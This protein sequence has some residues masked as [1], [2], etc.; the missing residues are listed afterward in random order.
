MRL[1]CIHERACLYLR[2]QFDRRER[3]NGLLRAS[4]ASDLRLSA[5][6]SLQSGVS[7]PPLGITTALVK[8]LVSPGSR[9]VRADLLVPWH[10]AKRWSSQN[11]PGRGAGTVT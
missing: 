10:A 4:H 1:S 8:R 2:N 9:L 11:A 3:G 5:R 6:L 7:K